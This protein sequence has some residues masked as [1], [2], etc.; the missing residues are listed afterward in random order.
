LKILV[1]EDE[2]L[3]SLMVEDALEDA[4]F[5]VLTAPNADD[6]LVILERDTVDVVFTD[7]DMPGSMDGLTLAANVRT[8][9]P[10]VHIIIASGKRRPTPDELPSDAF[11]FPKPYCMDHVINALGRMA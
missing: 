3:I 7:I 9:W 11:F 4:G 5:S 10:P 2:T 1:V 6:A 8:R